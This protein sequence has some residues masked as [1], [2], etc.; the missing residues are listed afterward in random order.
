[1]GLGQEYGFWKWRPAYCFIKAHT[2]IL[3]TADRGN[4]SRQHVIQ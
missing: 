3:I 1:M 2:Q 4:K